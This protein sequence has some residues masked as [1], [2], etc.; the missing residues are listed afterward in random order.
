M[1]NSSIPAEWIDRIFI[2]LSE[3]FGT[4]FASRFTNSSY[5]D[6]EKT[7]WQNGLCGLT[8]DQIKN[9]IDLCKNGLVNEPPSVVE[10]FHYAKGLRKPP[11]PKKSDY[12]RTESQQKLGEQYL[13]LITD[14]LHGRL[15]QEGEAALS[16]LDKQILGKQADPPKTHWQD[17]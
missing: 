12:T 6:I 13:K 2:R 17:S 11:S 15:D 10:F 3:I 16:A 8:A 9:V 14:K 1:T 5:I 7:R 4:K